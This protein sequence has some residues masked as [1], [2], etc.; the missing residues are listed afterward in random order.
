MTGFNPIG[1]IVVLPRSSLHPQ[2]PSA[3]YRWRWGDLHFFLPA[4]KLTPVHKRKAVC[5]AIPF[6]FPLLTSQIHPEF[7]LFHQLIILHSIHKVIRNH[8]R[9]H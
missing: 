5:I 9:T 1:S 4:Q 8:A 3:G 6:F 7:Q 2:T